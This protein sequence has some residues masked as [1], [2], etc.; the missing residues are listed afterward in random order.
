[1][2]QAFQRFRESAGG[3]RFKAVVGVASLLVMISVLLCTLF[4]LYLERNEEVAAGRLAATLAPTIA[5]AAG[6]ALAAEDPA[7]AVQA[8]VAPLLRDPRLARLIVQR[9]PD[10]IFKHGR[11]QSVLPG[12]TT[13]ADVLSP[14]GTVIGRVE[15]AIGSGTGGWSELRWRAAVISCG[16]IVF[17]IAGTMFLVGRIVSPIHDLVSAT[18]RLADGDFEVRLPTDGDGEV[19]ALAHHFN[20][21]TDRLRAATER[22]LEWQ[23]ELQERV[24]AKTREIEETRQHLENIVENVGASIIVADVDGSIVSANTHTQHLFG[25][26]PEFSIGRNLSEFG[27]DGRSAAVI[28]AQIA[29]AGGP[30]V[31]EAEVSLDDDH[32]RSLLVT[33]TLLR[34]GSGRAAGLM[35][36][37]K[38]ITQLKAMER[39]LVSSERLSAM[40]EMAGEIGHELNNYLMAIGGRAELIGVALKRG[41]D[42]RSLEKV[43]NGAKIIADQVAEMR[44]LTD[45][46]LESARKETSPKPMD[47]NDLVAATI[48]FVKPQ[49]KFDL[50]EFD[51]KIASGTLDV[52]ADPQQLRQVVLNLLS[53]AGE[54]IGD[55]RDTGGRILVET[56]RQDDGV[57]VRVSDNGA[58][59]P[60]SVRRR[61][62]EPH[63]T[64]KERGHGFGLAVCH[65]VIE[66]HG[67]RIEVKSKPGEGAT[68]VVYLPGS[69]N[70]GAVGSPASGASADA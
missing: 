19:A 40:G 29:A 43:K 30:V 17:G 13:H 58:G 56:V 64:T 53:N 6:A 11:T 4:V 69:V 49:N 10:V 8:S 45:G 16:M 62:F 2:T 35:Q 18:R 60:E 41:A 9:G 26:K 55:Y 7:E 63:F 51:V 15:V 24:D 70:P 54:S 38:D 39:R 1:M 34:D 66:N 68:F 27:N 20:E 14:D 22:R 32:V 50:I 23:R 42:A 21:M 44:R 47:L 67:G 31:T 57:C 37:A 5:S 52:F 65:R 59:M 46:L 48:D 3:F 61:I 12:A 33:H 25:A 36:I 28:L